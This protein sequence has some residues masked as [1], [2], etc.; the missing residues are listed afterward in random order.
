MFKSNLESTHHISYAMCFWNILTPS[1]LR[2]ALRRSWRSLRSRQVASRRCQCKPTAWRRRCRDLKKPPGVVCFHGEPMGSPW[3]L[4]VIGLISIESIADLCMI[5]MSII[6]STSRAVRNL[7]GVTSSHLWT[8][9]RL[10]EGGRFRRDMV[11]RQTCS[12]HS[13]PRLRPGVFSPPPAYAGRFIAIDRSFAASQK[14]SKGQ[15]KM[16]IHKMTHS[17]PEK[18]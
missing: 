17:N 1:G 18:R 3:W 12:D 10:L 5:C 4:E 14:A 8:Q 7:L 2:C 11:Q 16:V 6:Q 15:S 13:V 9:R